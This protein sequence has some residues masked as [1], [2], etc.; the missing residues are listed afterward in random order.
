[1]AQNIS[2]IVGNGFDLALGINT[3]YRHFYE[4]I[5]SLKPDSSNTI[6]SSIQSDPKTWAD[7]EVKLG[8]HS[9]KIEL[10]PESDRKEASHSLLEE[11]AEFTDDLGDYLEGQ[12]ENIN[13][14]LGF[15][16]HAFYQELPEGQRA[17]I[18]A[19]VNSSSARFRFVTLNYTKGLEKTLPSVGMHLGDGSVIEKIHHVHG[20]LLE[21]ITLGVND[22]SQLS[23]AI[24][25]PEKDYL[26]KPR[27]I[28]R[29]N[30]GRIE[31][32]D[33]IINSS[34]IIVLFGT[35]I[36]ETDKYIWQKV[37][38]WLM[39]SP[40]RLMVIHNYDDS[41]N[42]RARRIPWRTSL[43]GGE[44]QNLLLEHQDLDDEQKTELRKR[45]FVVHNTKE[46]F[47]EQ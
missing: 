38:N 39:Q 14:K 43:L 13:V 28:E 29:T 7:F 34:S 25:Q 21:N 42:E 41:Y 47:K 37:I 24:T 9:Q 36:G 6:Y 44:I 16:K 3:D 1:M 46:L 2:F 45:I 30:D 8:V 18:G 15:S 10:V 32:M 31:Q 22:E 33:A 40:D 12:E 26:I 27:S 23:S 35:S 5:S 19:I 17:R 20:D 4:H 11:L